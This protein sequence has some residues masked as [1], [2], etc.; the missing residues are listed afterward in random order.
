MVFPPPSKY[1]ATTGKGF[2][3]A[4]QRAR[5]PYLVRNVL[6]GVALLSFTAAVYSYA[7]LAVKQDD[8][9]DIPLPSPPPS[10]AN[11]NNNKTI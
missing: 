11:N 6:T 7:I 3:P 2:T 1:Q 5:R 8:L 9:G 4:L 10:S